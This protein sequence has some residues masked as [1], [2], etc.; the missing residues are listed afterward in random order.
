MKALKIGADD[1]ENRELRIPDYRRW[2]ERMN[3]G[4]GGGEQKQRK[5]CLVLLVYPPQPC[6]ETD[7]ANVTGN[8]F[9]PVVAGTKAH[10]K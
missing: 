2:E 10:K 9:S 4:K 1:F 6:M 7:T 5:K 8:F 3:R